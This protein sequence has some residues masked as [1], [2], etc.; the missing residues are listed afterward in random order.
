MI[1]SCYLLV[2]AGLPLQAIL[3]CQLS[4]IFISSVQMK[5]EAAGAC[6]LC[7]WWLDRVVVLDLDHGG[8]SSTVRLEDW[9]LVGNRILR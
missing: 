1:P 2:L 8:T 9:L 7:F 3:K 6:P 5:K 4:T